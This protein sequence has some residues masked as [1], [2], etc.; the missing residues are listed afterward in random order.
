MTSIQSE[1]FYNN[2]NWLKICHDHCFQV[3]HQ[4]INSIMIRYSIVEGLTRYINIWKN[5]FGNRFINLGISG[6]CVENV[7]WRARDISLLPSL[8]NVVVLCGKNNI[9]KDTPYDMVQDLIGIGSVCQN[10]SSN[11]NIFICDPR[12]ESFSVNRLIINE[13][14]ISLNPNFQLRIFIL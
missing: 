13:V 14:I 6:D 2:N 9:N 7:L 8:Q 12:D 4:N 11:T 1:R 5:R 3:K 10:Q